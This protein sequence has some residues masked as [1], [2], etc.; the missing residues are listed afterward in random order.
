MLIALECLVESLGIDAIKPRQ[1]GIEH[2][3]MPPNS[4]NQRLKPLVADHIV[5]L[6]GITI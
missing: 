1:I 4:E 3:P 6:P 2:H 5:P